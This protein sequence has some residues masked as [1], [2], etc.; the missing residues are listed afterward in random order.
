MDVLSLVFEFM[1]ESRGPLSLS[2]RQAANGLTQTCRS[3]HSVAKQP[4]EKMYSFF[5]SLQEDASHF[6]V[7]VGGGTSTWL[8]QQTKVVQQLNLPLTFAS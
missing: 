3:I 4:L 7:R 1:D 5:S 6:C 8:C 2:V